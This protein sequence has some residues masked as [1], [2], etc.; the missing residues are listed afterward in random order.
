MVQVTRASC[1]FSMFTFTLS[2][3]VLSSCRFSSR[4][5]RVWEPLPKKMWRKGVSF[6]E[7]YGERKSYSTWSRGANLGLYFHLPSFSFLICPITSSQTLI[8][9]Q[10]FPTAALQGPDPLPIASAKVS[11]VDAKQAEEI[12]VCTVPMAPKEDAHP[13]QHSSFM[14]KGKPVADTHLHDPVIQGSAD[15]PVFLVTVCDISSQCICSSL[16]VTTGK[17]Q[18]VQGQPQCL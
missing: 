16:E 10:P 9:T 11:H 6:G 18:P 1:S 15:D 3:L 7:R 2:L 14:K 8:P 4:L 17:K 5:C 12:L 13:S